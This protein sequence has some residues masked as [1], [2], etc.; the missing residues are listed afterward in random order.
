[1]KAAIDEGH[2]RGIKFTGH[3][4]SVPYRE[5]V[6]FGIDAIEHGMFANSDYDKTRKPDECSPNMM[7]SFV[8]LDVNGPEVQATFKDMI[9]H[10]VP[11]TSTLVVFELFVPGRPPELDPR[12][13]EAMSPEAKSEYLASHNKITESGQG[14]PLEIFKKGMEYEVAFYKAG[15]ILASGVDPTGNGGALFGFGDQRNVE[16]LV[17]AG[18]TP[19][20]AIQVATSNGAKALGI[21]DQTGSIAVGK[22]G[23]LALIDGNP[24]ANIA[25]IRKVE[26]V[27]H[28]GLT[29]D[30]SKMI[31]AVKGL[32]GTR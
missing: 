24:A 12:A 14:I 17:E 26:L 32:V 27:F 16:L 30:S 4:C 22:Q 7:K 10:K 9:S 31:A 11:L 19:I 2:K 6:A 20:Q 5:A 18:L 15:G 21:F 13:L 1:M 28:N 29:F 25:D 8:G 23:D 3:L